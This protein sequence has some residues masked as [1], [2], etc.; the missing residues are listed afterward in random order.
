MTQFARFLAA[1]GISANLGSRFLLNK[2]MSFEV[3]V[4]IALSSA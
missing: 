1:G 2:F 3:A 4:V